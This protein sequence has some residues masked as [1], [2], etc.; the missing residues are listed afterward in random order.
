MQIFSFTR[1]IQNKISKI[2]TPA[3]FF[4]V[5]MCFLVTTLSA[6]VTTNGSSGLAPTYTTIAGAISDL[7][8]ATIVAPV[9]I[10]INPGYTETAP[11]GGFVITA[12]GTL[13]NPITISK[14]TGA[15]S[16]P[17]IIAPVGTI[18]LSTSAAVVDGI[19]A[20]SGSDYI[21]FDGIDLQDN[22][23]SGA[24]MMEYGYGFFKTSA[25]DG[26]QNN[27]IRNC[28]ITLNK[29]N[30]I[31]GTTTTFQ[32]GCKGIYFGNVVRTAMTA[33]I[34]ITTAT[35]RNNGNTIIGNTVQ[36]C[37]IGIYMRGFGDA[38][39][40]F[41]N[42]D[43]NNSIGGSS[44]ALGNTVRNYGTG[45]LATQGISTFNQNNL[46]V[47]YN[48]VN[49][50]AGGGSAHGGILLGLNISGS[51][52][53]N[54]SNYSIR[55]NTITLGQGINTSQTQGISIGTAGGN[56]TVNIAD[57][58][59]TGFTNLSGP[60]G[61]ALFGIV[62]SNTSGNTLNI[63]NNTFSG[64]TM[65]GGCNMISLQ[66]SANSLTT[67]ITGNTFTNNTL[68]NGNGITIIN[69]LTAATQATTSMN[70]NNNLV[71][72]LT[73]A[74]ANTANSA[75]ISNGMGTGACNLSISGNDFKNINYNV[76]STGGLTF[77]NNVAATL[78]QTI[79][80][81]KFTNLVLNTAGNVTFMGDN[82][83]LSSAGSKTVSNNSIIT[84][85]NKTGAGGT[86]TFF[87]TGSL[88]V[89]GSAN[90]ASNNNFS[91]ITVTGATTI[92][93]WVNGEG[94]STTDGPA[95]TFTGNT[96]NN[97]TGGT[98]AVTL[99]NFNFGGGNSSLTLNTF[100][101]VNSGGSITALALG[102]SNNLASASQNNIN[103]LLSSGASST[104]TGISVTGGTAVALN[105]NDI[106]TLSGS[107]ITSPIV[108]GVSVAGGTTVNVSK[109]KIYDISE[110][111][112]IAT[113]A[114]AVRG[115]SLSG[116]TTVNVFNNLLGDLRAPSANLADA[117]RA[118]NVSSVTA[119]SN[120]NVYFN[121]IHLNASSAGSNF[122]T[123]GIYHAANATA[124]TA[125]LDLRNNI[126]TNLSIPAGTGITSALFRSVSNTLA[127]YA[128]TSD[129]NLYFAGSP[130]ALNAI[131]NDNGTVYGTS[132]AVFAFG[133]VGLA[134]S[135]Q[136]QVTSAREANSFTGE[137]G[138]SFSTP[139]SFFQSLTGS[140]PNFLHIVAGI[141]S[142][143]ESGAAAISSPAITDDFDGNIRNTG[144]PDIG[145]D[146]FVGISP[147]PA[148]TLNSIVP[149]ITA[150]CIATARAISVNITSPSGSTSSA[151]LNYSFNG[152]A[153][154]PVSMV[155]TSG[156]T[157]VA[158]IAAA[159]PGNASVTWTVTA[160]NSVPLTTVYT[161]S[162]YSDEPLTGV[163]AAAVA[164]I[165]P[166]CS[167]TPTSLSVSVT[168]PIPPA[169]AA[170]AYC[171]ST[172]TS[173]CS[174]DNIARVV[175]N[176]LDKT[177]GTACGSPAASAYG[178]FSGQ[179]GA[180]TTTLNGNT[181]YSLSLTF[182][183]DATQFFGAWIDYNHDGI[184]GVS[185]FLGASG[186]AGASGT[187]AV[188]FTVPATAYNGLTHLR[189][190]GGN[191]VA[192]TASQA[193]G[194]SSSPFGETQ[195]YDVTITGRSSYVGV[196]TA[197]SWSDGTNAVGTT[198]PLVVNPSSNTS[199]TATVTSAGCTI[200]SN[201]VAV[202]TIS[203]PAAPSTAPSSQ[204]GTGVPTCFAVGTANGNYRWYTVP[205]GGTAIA[206][207]VN[208]VLSI[209]SI[210]VT[211]TF[212]V[213]LTNNTCESLRTPV[214]ASVNPPDVLVASS[215]GPVCANST[216]TL[217]ATVTTNTNANNYTYSWAATASAGSGIPTS[218]GGG[219][220][221]FGSPASTNVTPTLGGTYSYTVTA[222]DG[223]QGCA[224]T[225]TVS[226]TINDL[227]VISSATATPGA[228]CSGAAVTL[229]A[230]GDII[231]SGPQSLPATYCV[232]SSQGT[233]IITSVTLNALSNTGI[234]QS[235]PFYTIY[236]ASG[237]TTTSLN[238]GTT[239]SISLT[240]NAATIISVWID[241]NR[242]GVF[243]ASEW[244]QPWTNAA[245]GSINITIPP[246]AALGATGLRIRSRLATFAN[247]ATDACSPMG[248][249]SSQD[250]T[251][252]IQNLV[253][254]NYTYVWN[255][256]A[257]PGSSVIVNPTIP[258]TYVVTA[259]NPSTGCTNTAS[260]PVTVN[261]VPL[262]VSTTGSEQCGAAIPGALV[263][264][265]SG[266]TSPVF[267]WYNAPTA[268]TL[269]QSNTSTSFLTAIS[270]TTTFYVSEIS[271]F[272]CESTRTPVTIIVS[273]P[274]PLTIT[275]SDNNLCIGEPT[276]LTSSYTP[277]F[278]VFTGF[279]L[280][281]NP[282][283][284]SGILN[285]VSLG[286]NSTGS[287]PFSVTPTAAG[288]YTY[289]ITANDPDR[290]CNSVAT[291][292]VT[293]NALPAGLTAVATPAATCAGGLINLAASVTAPVPAFI[294]GFASVVPLPGG[295]AE[296]NL[297]APAGSITTWSQGIASPG[298]FDAHSAPTTSYARASFNNV[299]GANDISNWLFAPTVTLHN[300]DV[301]TFWTRTVDAPAFADNL[302]VRMS[303]NGASTNVGASAATVGDY[304]NLL[305]EINPTL[306]PTA[307]PNVWT[308]YNVTI[309]GLGAPTTGR[310]AF[311]Y[312]VL[313]GGPLG[314]NSDNIGIDDVSYVTP[315]AINY[316]W[317][318]S[319][320]GFTSNVQNPTG[321]L[322]SQP[323]TFIVTATNPA[324]GCISLPQS[325]LVPLLPVAANATATPNTVVCAG[326]AVTLGA[327]ATGGAPFTYSWSNGTGV[328]GTTSPL[329]VNPAV[330]T[331]YTVTVLD[332]CSNSTT[333]SITVNVNPLPA[334]SVSPGAASFCNPLGSPVVLTASGASTYVWAPL[335]GLSATT[336]SVVTASPAVTTIYTVTGTD[337][338]GCVNTATANITVNPNPTA[339]ASASPNPVCAGSV[340]TLTSTAAVQAIYQVVPIAYAP[341]TD[342]GGAT[343]TSGDDAVSA[344]QTIPF[345]F[346]FYG[347]DYTS[348]FA[349]SN[350]FIQLGSSSAS[351][352]VYGQSLPAAAAPNNIIAGVFNDLFV[353]GAGAAVRSYTTGIA[354]N[355][356]FTVHY[357]NV[358]FYVSGAG[359]G[360]T[361]FYI[362]LYE[363][364]NIIEVHVADNSGQSSS[365]NT[366][367][368]GI[369]NITGT[370]ATTPTGRNFA[371][372]NVAPANPEAWR[373]S[374][375]TPAFSYTWS[376]PA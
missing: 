310:I 148:V 180:N 142:R 301:F 26:C 295:W 221:T 202:N 204:C 48:N 291:V 308:Q 337:G 98:N 364:T 261:P 143:V 246:G 247:G 82:V 120:Y 61:G 103:N 372:W 67:S 293:V 198:N 79:N 37:F 140:N 119:S 130:G 121:T 179:T 95:K 171:P 29:G 215:N 361:D 22:N 243:E 331:T 286:V 164:S 183:S 31:A 163:T 232:P 34:V 165:N 145:A 213:S 290:G 255:P 193:C 190:V 93:G 209:T 287:N 70:I 227:P 332:A 236:P 35:G 320:A 355:R 256:G 230:S 292:T 366:K 270:V 314:A 210:A 224:T 328:I 222:T 111:G 322:V 99:A 218:V 356:I 216:L 259:T 71:D 196:V 151:T 28:V 18:T 137:I 201:T 153:Q 317:T 263:S 273:D 192:V 268:G 55:N 349:Y 294:E 357:N 298:L 187:I 20:L 264:S 245:T 340:L 162:G 325:V 134:G 306:T 109:N 225:S 56:G 52:T 128:T 63:T 138:F 100:S 248:S 274:D 131:L 228:V 234:A 339:T 315:T 376:G 104:I 296:Q 304:T 88:S 275:A 200:I 354:P 116:G 272:G 64:N 321:V 300:G 239:Y 341:T 347:I 271:T 7:N 129:R 30:N 170:S 363:T 39:T 250:Y 127:N 367:T 141:T 217:T 194:A 365:N 223:V 62:V 326:S 330:T 375:A 188:P 231:T 12:T 172:H 84:A 336:G 327:G 68:S 353:T 17:Q 76:A 373:F 206:G 1:L 94:S 219:T 110:T 257:L 146:E 161:G 338:N 307:Y 177:T 184:Y 342:P 33:D 27:T 305:L 324:T 53:L 168:G 86:V 97:I 303:T 113:T 281:A 66:A 160:V 370:E 122:G 74:A 350:G 91:N 73:Y 117:I 60:T 343:I 89:N 16:N 25:S 169:P 144:N 284:G 289:T 226:V 334:V 136:A 362:L 40:P 23:A 65:S 3:T 344:A 5:I 102:S 282:E 182:G 42:I 41:L 114:G 75:M 166:V 371:A 11:A 19:V 254:T 309:S 249:G 335:T 152:I 92:A 85:F 278:N 36:N 32:D 13:S 241:F 208:D 313:N 333:S 185:E 299:A 176:T 10:S 81:N 9:L 43:Q 80:G 323:T 112:A 319:P 8:T 124:T 252:N 24:A 173:G 178:N 253:A 251:V 181:G 38:V 175:L 302:Q 233:G 276:V 149:G 155:N 167:G 345:N 156:S 4:A 297:S 154:T 59:L 47:Q 135:F 51:V 50:T 6:Q 242:N 159:S 2:F 205:T 312:F 211:T 15:G 191:D 105:G 132:S 244:F 83:T 77:I 258:T 266:A 329:T 157:W 285:P 58:L 207:E 195:D 260:I 346:N 374:P 311:R 72:G 279:T 352:T 150:Q 229:T 96:F 139:G 214:V 237:S 174:G 288:I 189:I 78:T 220:G 14:G 158:T 107:G 199:Y 277:D 369:E 186:N 318:S 44:P 45:T 118:I 269:V 240:T 133:P 57:N 358:P 267:N 203:L 235:T 359:G 49:N 265:N 147:A 126:V 21:T 125:K 197:Y 360:N 262:A 54:N 123:T 101:N 106:H 115:I 69:A 90:N 283:T 368:L 87:T 348:V 316:S 351:A 108:N 280:T 46:L 212:Y 238:R